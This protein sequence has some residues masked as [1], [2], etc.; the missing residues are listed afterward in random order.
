MQEVGQGFSLHCL[1]LLVRVTALYTQSNDAAKTSETELQ[2]SW[3]AL[4]REIR[5]KQLIANKKFWGF[6]PFMHS[7]T[8]LHHRRSQ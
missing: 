2:F 4:I 7:E 5:E 1:C 8:N 6:P 3:Q